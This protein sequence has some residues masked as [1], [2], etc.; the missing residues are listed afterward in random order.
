MK[1]IY[2]P[3]I[4]TLGLFNS[5][6]TP[7]IQFQDNVTKQICVANWDTNNDGEIQLTEAGTVSKLGKVFQATDITYFEELQ[8][9]TNLN[10]IGVED[11]K[12][13]SKLKFIT[14]PN[15]V[16]KIGQ[17]AFYGCTSLQS[18]NIPINVQ[19]IEER[20]FY[21]CTGALTIDSNIIGKDFERETSPFYGA[22]F[23]TVHIGNQ[24]SRIG[25]YAFTYC[26]RISNISFPNSVKSIGLAAF[27][28]CW[29]LKSIIIPENVMEIQSWTFS[30][31]RNLESVTI[32]NNINKIRSN[33]FEGCSS[34]TNV[35]IPDSVK[36]V[37][38][39]AFKNCSKL[40]TL[41]WGNDISDI[42][43]E[44]FC[45]CA[46]LSNITMPK[47]VRWFGEDIFKD[48]TA[49][50]V[51]KDVRYA[52][53]YVVGAV[54]KNKESYEIK[55]GSRIIGNKAFMDCKNLKNI[56]LPESVTTIDNEAFKGCSS[57]KLTYIHE[58]ITSIGPDAF[59]EC[60]G[61]LV[62]DSKLVESDH[63][64]REV[65]E[66]RYFCYY[67][68]S[69]YWLDG[70]NFSKITIGDNIQKL[71]NNIFYGRRELKAITIPKGILSIGEGAL[72]NCDKLTHVY[73]K[74]EFPPM[75]NNLDLKRLCIIHVPKQSVAD[76]KSIP[77]W[78]KY[79]IITYEH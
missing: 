49:L 53:T 66:G 61:E 8:Y 4:I 50:P 62:I 52:D 73:C 19:T 3:L 64:L 21:Y 71:G 1:K 48:C 76:Y 41:V 72:D 20:A 39:E 63:E 37:G 45:G 30:N 47:N 6:T 74:A 36:E 38:W 59:Y 65:Y 79:T 77:Q 11:F 22:N 35:T 42:G 5:C 16:S 25:D 27:A 58:N 15:R 69:N 78:G 24:I 75:T 14:I 44:A 60:T 29:S 34:L 31:C 17:R 32:P 28:N 18:I 2:I 55:E 68:S 7:I 33:A 23:T 70:A 57:L 13:C 43:N 67:K 9:F 10:E 56:S 46:K 26:T 51:D 12:D 54:N 40:T